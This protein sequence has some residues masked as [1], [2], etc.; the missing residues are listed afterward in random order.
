MEINID[1][2]KSRFGRKVLK[3]DIIKIYNQFKKINDVI[4]LRLGLEE[5]IV[6]YFK[7]K[8]NIEIC[9]ENISKLNIE[10]R[11]YENDLRLLKRE[12]FDCLRQ[13]GRLM[14]FLWEIDNQKLE[15][16]LNI[17]C[18]RGEEFS[19]IKLERFRKDRDNYSRNYN[20]LNNDLN[21]SRVRM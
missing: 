6:K 8:L 18:I 3:E 10:I 16:L 5:S 9:R 11:G 19:E 12:E 13:K 2:V 21:V 20:E 17:G 4:K 1:R 7:S 15:E 14:E